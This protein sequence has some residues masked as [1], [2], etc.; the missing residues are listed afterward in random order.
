MVFRGHRL[1]YCPGLDIPCFR[2]LAGI[3]AFIPLIHQIAI[4]EV[5]WKKK[6]K[7][8]PK[9]RLW[10][11]SKCLNIQHKQQTLL[12]V[13]QTKMPLHLRTCPALFHNFFNLPFLG[14]GSRAGLSPQECGRSSSSFVEFSRPA[15]GRAGTWAARASTFSVRGKCILCFSLLVGLSEA[16]LSSYLQHLCCSDLAATPLV[17]IFHPGAL[18]TG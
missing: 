6:K 12:Y 5:T 14:L 11:L 17:V 3:S 18:K 13:I 2:E 9:H 16:E 10:A 7:K 15:P 4:S 1:C 8:A